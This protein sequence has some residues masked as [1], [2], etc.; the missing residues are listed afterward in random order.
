MSYSKDWEYSTIA[1]HTGSDPCPVTGALVSP[2]YQTS[3]YTY[4]NTEE[5]GRIFSGEQFGYLYGRD[6]SPTEYELEDKIAA[7][8]VERLVKLLPLECRPYLQYIYHY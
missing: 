1:V 8:K 7:Q 2:I 3:T 4:K 6:H 5:A